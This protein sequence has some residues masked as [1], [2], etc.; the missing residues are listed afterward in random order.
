MQVGYV[1]LK[2]A[3]DLLK[4]SLAKGKWKTT[5]S[6]PKLSGLIKKSTASADLEGDV[7]C[8]FTTQLSA[9][10]W[11]ILDEYLL[12]VISVIDDQHLTVSEPVTTSEDGTAEKL[13]SVEAGGYSELLIEKITYLSYAY[14]CILYSRFYSI[15]A[16]LTDQE[17]YTLQKAQAFL[18]AFTLSNPTPNRHLRNQNNGIVSESIGDTSVDYINSGKQDAMND[19]PP[20]VRNIMNVFEHKNRTVKL[21][22]TGMT[23]N[24][25]D[26]YY[27]RGPEWNY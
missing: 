15:P 3:D 10:D 8:L 23:Q 13:S 16:E 1:T 25:V 2:Q 9:G 19:F 12:Q 11:I 20:E 14:D 26:V 6:Y 7:N 18:A 22:R 21:H 5:P 4:Y 17:Y 27:P 24:T